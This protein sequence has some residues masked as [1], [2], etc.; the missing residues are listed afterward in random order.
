MFNRIFD[1]W[2]G[3]GDTLRIRD[4]LIRVERDVEIDLGISM[5][6]EYCGLRYLLRSWRGWLTLIRTLLSLRSTSVME[7]LFE[8]DMIDTP[9][10][11]DDIFRK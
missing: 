11:L 5:D 7:S 8:R 10:D 2:D 4:L 9:C 6:C 3:S 1:C